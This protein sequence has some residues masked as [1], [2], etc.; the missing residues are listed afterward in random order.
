MNECMIH[1]YY[2]EN[3]TKSIDESWVSFMNDN[4]IDSKLVAL[5][6]NFKNTS[7]KKHQ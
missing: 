3:K 2:T 4:Q 6:L 7:N 1:D 5:F